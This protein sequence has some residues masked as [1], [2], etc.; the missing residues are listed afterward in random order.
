MPKFVNKNALFGYFWAR[1]LKKNFIV[2]FE[3]GDLEFALLPKKKVFKFE[4]KNA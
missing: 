4:T 3:I 2:I 1:I